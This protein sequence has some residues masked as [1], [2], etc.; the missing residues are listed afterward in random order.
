MLWRFYQRFSAPIARADLSDTETNNLIPLFARDQLPDPGS[1]G[2][3]VSWQG[4]FIQGFVV[5]NDR[6]LF[7]YVNSCPHTG[8]PLDWV[9]HQ[10]LDLD[11]AFIQCASHDARF[12][13]T[14]GL[15]IA[16]PCV[17]QSL[18]RLQ[19][20]VIDDQVALVLGG[21]SE[22]GLDQSADAKQS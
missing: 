5:C 18:R 4:R 9:D 2:F 20:E 8:A 10:F 15:C 13:I 19:V 11:K 22:S 14:S 17:G 6:Q 12:E 16:G 7:A 1:R 3:S 21:L